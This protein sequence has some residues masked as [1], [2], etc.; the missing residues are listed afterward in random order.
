MLNSRLRI[1]DFEN[2]QMVPGKDNRPESKTHSAGGRI[3]PYT[4]GVDSAAIIFL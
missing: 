2:E 3:K 4:V 1:S